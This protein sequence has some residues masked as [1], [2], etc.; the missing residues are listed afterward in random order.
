M[1]S[2]ARSIVLAVLLAAGTVAPIPAFARVPSGMRPPA[3]WLRGQLTAIAAPN[4]NPTRFT[5]QTADRDV[6]MRI[7]PTATFTALSA[8]AEV[9]GLRAGD[10]A[11]VR[12]RHSGGGWIALHITFDVRPIRVPDQVTIVANV[13]RETADNRYL[14]VRLPSGMNRWVLMDARTKFRISG[15][16]SASPPIFESEELVHVIMRRV[17]HGWVAIEIDLMGGGQPQPR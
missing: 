12:A 10:Y 15:A 1:A 14:I 13:V 16:L 17:P 11:N 3:V 4:G 8:E 5:L 2:R 6:I 7:A 9:E